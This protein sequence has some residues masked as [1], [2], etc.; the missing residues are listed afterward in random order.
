MSTQSGFTIKSDE[1]QDLEKT[2]AQTLRK[3]T[4]TLTLAAESMTVVHWHW[5][6]WPDRGVPAAYLLALRLLA[7]IRHDKK[8]L[9][10]CSAGRSL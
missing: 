1:A 4:L 2:D 8:V 6:H 10:H 3:T 7:R 5:Q 9:V